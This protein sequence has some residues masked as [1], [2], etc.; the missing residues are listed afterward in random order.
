MRSGRLFLVCALSLVNGAAE[1]FASGR[2]GAWVA[3]AAPGP[4]PTVIQVKAKRF[5]Y[6]P[7]KIT[8]K[9][10]VPVVLELISEAAS[11]A[12]RCQSWAFVRTSSAREG[13]PTRADPHQGWNVCLRLRHLLR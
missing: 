8:L 3:S 11:T 6:L 10:G 1:W 2:A 13:G 9:Q 12:S 4:T 7:S 5:S